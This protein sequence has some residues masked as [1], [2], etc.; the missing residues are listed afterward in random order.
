MGYSIIDII[1]KAIGIVIRRKSEY[2]KIEE[3]KHDSQA[4]RVMSAVLVKEADRTIQYYKTLK[5]EVGSVEFEEIDFI[6]YDK[7]SFLIDQF[8]KKTYEHH[9]N[10]VKDYLKFSL[11]LE[12]DV[13][14]LL[15]D[16]QGRFV[17]NTSD[18]HTKTYEILSDIIDNK[19]NHIS[20]I[21][22]T[23]K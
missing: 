10:N 4:I 11:D 6:V 22:K 2:E 20:T 12:K 17:K 5:E 9:I 23:L 21:E 19:A 1:D 13:Y 3:E 7:M 16:V 14:S 15:V 8:N 18:T